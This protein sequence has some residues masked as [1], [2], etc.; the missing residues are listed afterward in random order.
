MN[1]I[2]LKKIG[3]LKDS[4]TESKTITDLIREREAKVREINA[5]FLE[6]SY[7]VSN[8]FINIFI[9]HEMPLNTKN[10]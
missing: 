3:N 2:D 4:S 1:S 9:F 7:M 8:F 6:S 5:K 10:R